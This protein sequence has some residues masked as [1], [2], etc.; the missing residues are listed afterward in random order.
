MVGKVVMFNSDFCISFVM[1]E[2]VLCGIGLGL[3]GG[4]FG[5][6]SFLLFIVF[7]FIYI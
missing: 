5:S 3:K 6:G 4:W 1:E 2:E 7:F